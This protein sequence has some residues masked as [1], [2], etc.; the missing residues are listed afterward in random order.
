MV[1]NIVCAIYKG[2]R[3]ALQYHVQ[4]QH[5]TLFSNIFLFQ[6]QKIHL[7]Q[8]LHSRW[9]AMSVF[10]KLLISLI[11]AIITEGNNPLH[12]RRFF[13]SLLIN[14]AIQEI[15]VSLVWMA[16][17]FTLLNQSM[18]LRKVA[19]YVSIK[20]LVFLLTPQKINIIKVLTLFKIN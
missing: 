12:T 4:H 13:S 7:K 3:P 8:L 18:Y 1:W 6:F 15:R 2:D 20:L 10:K 9:F 16:L 14:S 11:F 5:D 17:P 19:W